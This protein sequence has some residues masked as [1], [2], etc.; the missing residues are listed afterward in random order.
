MA[1]TDRRQKADAKRPHALHRCT[2]ADEFKTA[3]EALAGEPVGTLVRRLTGQPE[4]RG[5]VLGGSIPLA[6]GTE[7]SDVDLLVLVDGINQNANEAGHAKD[8]LFSGLFSGDGKRLAL[9]EIVAMIRGVEVN[10]Q[11]L[12]AN[13][14]VAFAERVARAGVSLTPYEIGL[15]S[16][17]KTGWILEEGP[18][19]DE[20]CRKPLAGDALEIHATI[21]YLVGAAQDREDAHAALSDSPML[22]VHLGRSSVERAIL[23]WFASCGFSYVGAKWLRAFGEGK[24]G[25]LVAAGLPRSREAF[26][27]LFP[28]DASLH[29]AAAY[30][31]TV[32]GFLR[33]TRQEIERKLPY[34]IAIALC[35]QL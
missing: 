32:D 6:L 28:G 35:P 11:L 10:C 18:G 13:A 19:F 25:P 8:V 26:A 7:R 29:G 4:P 21:W 22:A 16:R 20:Y 12:L 34:K 30:L 27:L 2:D 15:M 9:G 14:V 23:A 1:G 17:L 24:S 5:I 33:T 31:E 3:F